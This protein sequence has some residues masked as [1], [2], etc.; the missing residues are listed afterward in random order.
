MSPGPALPES[1]AAELHVLF[2]GYV[3]GRVASTVVLVVDGDARIVVDPGMVP[4]RRA[5]LDPLAG[6]GVDPT[7]VTDVV[8]SHHHPDHTL[9]A[10]L[11]PRARF[12]DHWAI[13]QDDRWDSRP[14]E[15]AVVSPS[16]RLAETPGHSPQD[17]TTLVATAEGLVAC[18]H[19]WWSA[20]GPADD[21]YAPDREL[22]RANRRRVLEVASMIVPGHGPAFR[23]D[24]STPL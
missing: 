1:S 15:G 7:E 13:Y 16:V 9:N 14:A 20:G 12:H 23:P 8:F 17:I 21:P 22:L 19:L 4:G 24:G 18:T 3:G 5:I 11:F 10:G 2:E 6:H